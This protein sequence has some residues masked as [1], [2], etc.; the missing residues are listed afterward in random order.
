[1]HH[2]PEAGA[3]GALCKVEN[4]EVVSK[5]DRDFGRDNRNDHDDNEWNRSKAGEEPENDQRAAYRLNAAHKGAHH[6]GERYS[7]LCKAPCTKDVGKYQF[8]NAFREED[9]EADQNPNQNNRP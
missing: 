8:L 6:I 1:M 3:L 7:N 2:A 4:P 5:Q 9:D